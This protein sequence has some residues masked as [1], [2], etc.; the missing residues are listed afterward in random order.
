MY[1]I[2]DTLI[3]TNVILEAFGNSRTNR[4]DNSSRFGKYMDLIF[5]YKFEPSGGQI[6]HYLLE[7]SR[8][9]KQQP[10]E[11]NFHAFYELLS[12]GDFFRDY[13]LH[14]PAED[15]HYINQGGCCRVDRIDD[16]RGYEQVMDALDAVGFTKDEICTIW[17]IVA[18]V[19]HLVGT[20]PR[21][22]L[23]LF[24]GF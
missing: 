6:Q 24:R 17:K 19:I 23:N 8:V 2:S 10:G 11:R 20:C 21:G 5:D 13:G 15:Y 16:R 22:F 1:R 9:V 18:A 4:N 14:L 7:K 3:Q 12:N